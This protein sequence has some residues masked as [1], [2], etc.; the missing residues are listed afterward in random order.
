[1]ECM[2]VC[3]CVYLSVGGT[4]GNG[5]Q[6]DCHNTMFPFCLQRRFKLF[7]RCSFRSRIVLFCLFV[8]PCVLLITKTLLF[9][10]TVHRQPTRELPNTSRRHILKQTVPLSP[11]LENVTKIIQ[12]RNL[13]ANSAGTPHGG[14]PLKMCTD[15]QTGSDSRIRPENVE[16]T[17]RWQ[18][19]VPGNDAV[20]LFAAHFDRRWYPNPAVVVI[21]LSD[22][23]ARAKSVPMYCR[24]WYRND[25]TPHVAPVH[26]RYS[27]ETHELR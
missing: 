18:Q 22:Y 8:L 20:Y 16:E 17:F 24:L 13:A 15:S 10:P 21:G 14:Y 12:L 4:A 2:C 9:S 3:V 23:N 25:V 7:R 6:I 5:A 11:Q 19:M 26:S 1:L 27:A